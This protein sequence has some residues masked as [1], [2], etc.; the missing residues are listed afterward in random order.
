MDRI[1][2]EIFKAFFGDILEKPKRYKSYPIALINRQINLDQ[3]LAIN[4]AMVYPVAYIQGP[5]G[6]G[7]TNTIINTIITAFFNERTVLFASYNN[8]PIDGVFDKLCQLKYHDKPIPFP[9]LR[10]G[11]SDKRK[12]A[13][14]YI[15][16]LMTFSV[17]HR[18]ARSTVGADRGRNRQEA[19]HF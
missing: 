10:L 7:K 9:I 6:T 11:N 3:L 2:K 5:P 17:Y 8:H 15:A 12:E 18:F 16:N 14:D 19:G 4:K 1:C 13:L